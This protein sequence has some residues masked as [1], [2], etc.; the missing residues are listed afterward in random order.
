MF[1]TLVKVVFVA[2]VILGITAFAGLFVMSSLA[3]I[4]GVHEVPVPNAS[5]LANE[6]A[7]ADYSDAY[8]IEMEFCPFRNIDD[9]A[10]NAFE[11]GSAELTRTDSEVMYE[12]VAPGVRYNISYILDRSADPPT[13]T[14]CTAAR[15]EGKTGMVYLPLVK[16]IHRMLVPYLVNRMSNATIN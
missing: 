2:A 13:L 10:A 7:R 12:G 6:A 15:K 1:R 9:V 14:V 4:N 11:R 5:V 3:R 8:R 16:P